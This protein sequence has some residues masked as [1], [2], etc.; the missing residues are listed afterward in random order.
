MGYHSIMEG[1]FDTL[2]EMNFDKHNDEMHKCIA[3]MESA[4]A[5][6]GAFS[7]AANRSV[8][9]GRSG[10]WA[11]VSFAAILLARQAG[12]FWPSSTIQWLS[13]RCAGGAAG[14]LITTL[15]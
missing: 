12:N 7:A 3:A 4:F 1:M 8:G 13:A 15:L 10:V 5:Q 2:K 6:M 14:S 11:P 9:A